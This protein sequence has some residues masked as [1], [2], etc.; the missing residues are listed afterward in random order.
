M[1]NLRASDSAPDCTT[2]AE[3]FL[4][5]SDSIL[6]NLSYIGLFVFEKN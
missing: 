6:K 4:S 2:L 5:S 1:L 3:P